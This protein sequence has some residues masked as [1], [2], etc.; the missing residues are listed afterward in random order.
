MPTLSVVVPFYNVAPY[1]PELLE[2]LAAQHLDDIE[3][4][5]VDDGSS[6]SSPQIA[7]SWVAKDERF[8]LVTQP[9]RG[10][11]A[12]RNAGAE[13]ATGTYLAFADSDDVVPPTA[14]RAL[15]DSLE[16]TG[17]DFASGDVRRLNSEGTH[18]HPR[19]ADVF[20]AA[21]RR[22][23]ITRDHDL[24]LDRMIW[25]KVFRRSFWDLHRLAFS[26]AQYEDAPVTVRAHIEAQAVDVVGQVV[27]HWRIRE[28]GEPS[29]TQR[30]YEPDNIAARMRM[31]VDTGDIL[32]EH[33]PGLLPAYE[34]D[35]CLGDLRIAMLAM[36]ENTDAA[37]A[38]A[39]D[40]GRGFLGRVD[41]RVLEALPAANRHRLAL[42]LTGKSD[43]LREDLRADGQ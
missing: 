5:L 22:T 31:M 18:R 32:R 34:R 2:S 39:L 29:I 6:D 38:T 26:L 21:R 33:A 42:L 41:E 36:L 19:Y 14:Y 17:S 1:F 12:A 40:L 25:N 7:S 35:M 11:S 9:N 24:I 10:L 27:Y 43:E 3:V 28:A 4:V 8:S 16:S 13:Q 37:M 20:A 23:H 15:V 30:L